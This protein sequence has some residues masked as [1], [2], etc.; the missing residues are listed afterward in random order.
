MEVSVFYTNKKH[1][2]KGNL[3]NSLYCVDEWTFISLHF[4]YGVKRV[5]IENTFMQNRY[6]IDICNMDSVF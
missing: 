3:R 2:K 1:L 5:G 6:F 4:K